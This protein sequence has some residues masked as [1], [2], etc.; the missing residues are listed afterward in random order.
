MQ[1]K[2]LTNVVIYTGESEKPVENGF[3]RFAEKIVEVG[4]MSD[5][6]QLENEETID[7]E[8]RIVIPGMIDVHIHG[9]HGIDVMDADSEKLKFLSKQF[10]VEGVTSFFATTITQSDKAIEDA[11]KSVKVAMEDP[12]TTIEGVHLEGPFFH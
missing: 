1:T 9:G 10:L 6:K 12:A 3:I 2:V 5:W 4:E 7:G 11:L 8:G